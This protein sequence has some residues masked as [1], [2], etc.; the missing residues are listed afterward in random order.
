MENPLN[1]SQFAPSRWILAAAFVAIAA[2]GLAGYFY[3]F[4]PKE[5]CAPPTLTVGSRV[6]E[7]ETIQKAG[8]G[9]IQIPQNG[10]NI[11]YWVE[12]TNTTLVFG[13][14]PTSANLALKDSIQGGETAKV[15][16]GNCN[17]SLYTLRAPEQGQPDPLSNQSTSG[18]TIFLPNN[19]VVKGDL[20]QEELLTIPSPN[21]D[22][23]LAEISLLETKTSADKMTITVSVSIVNQGKSAIKVTS[24][25]VTLLVADSEVTPTSSTPTLPVEIAAG[26]TQNLVFTFARPNSPAATLKIF[27]AEY[28]LE[29]Y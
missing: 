16:W 6:F 26:A 15:T 14:S 18:I 29:G 2:L 24:N 22:D 1:N 9:S 27:N 12:G 19:A 11:A 8:D 20:S 5:P 4:R 28:E 13:L 3:F 25:D 23:M 21:P 7:I 10:E 17:S